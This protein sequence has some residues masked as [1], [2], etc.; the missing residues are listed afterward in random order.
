M[1]WYNFQR[2]PDAL[3]W[4]DDVVYTKQNIEKINHHEEK[5]IL[6]R[7]QKPDYLL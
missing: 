7:N 3:F 5:N 2:Y 1:V 4:T 6:W